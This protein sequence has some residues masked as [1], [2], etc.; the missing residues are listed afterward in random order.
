MDGGGFLYVLNAQNGRI[1]HKIATEVAGV[2]VGTPGTPSGLAQ[3]NNY[4]D[5]V[6]IDNTTLRVYG[7]DVLGNMWRFDFTPSAAATLLATAKDPSNNVQPITVRPELAELD[8]KPFV[9]F[10]TG[11]LLGATDVTDARIQS[12]YGLRDT[13]ATGSTLYPTPRTSF[14]PMQVSQTGTGATAVRTISC[15]GSPGDCGRTEGWVLDLAEPGER[16][17]VEMK[18]V[19][20]ALV[21]ASNVPEE[22]PCSIGGHSWFNQIDFRTGAPIPGA[23]TS[24]YLS[25]SLNVGFVVLQLPPPAGVTNPTYTGLFRQSKGENVN[26]RITPPEPFP[27]GKRISWR[28]IAQ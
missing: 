10:G 5:N 9:M 11:K 20:G 18:L 13:L 4:V 17:N 8:G 15:T 14:R 24:E 27:V 23:I 2:N 12:V 1:I 21:F 19:L 22:V 3:I 26:R 6:V 28:E 7:G 25:D 16:V